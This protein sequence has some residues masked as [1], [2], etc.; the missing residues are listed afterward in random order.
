MHELL[1][2]APIPAS[3]HH[4]LLQ[5]LTGLTAMQPNRTFERR[6][7]FKPYRRPGFVRPRPGGSQDVQ[8]TE[9]QKLQKMLNSGLYHMQV[10]G[11]IN[12]TD[13]GVEENGHK[14]D[15]VMGGMESGGADQRVKP[16]PG[17]TP[18][19]QVWKVEFKDTPE[20][21]AGSGVTSRGASTAVLPYGDVV[22]LMKAW[23]YDYIS[24]YVVEGNMF[25]LDDTVLF[26]HRILNYSPG[27]LKDPSRPTDSLPP[28]EQ[29]VPLDPSGTYILQASVTVQDVNPDMLK[30]AAHRLLRMKDRLKSVAKLEPA[31]RLA[32]DT[33]VK[34]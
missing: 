14:P 30:A 8:H 15:A 11:A 3:Q 4:D 20:A 27:W 26:L 9:V 29:L 12:A 7:I 22:P 25:I 23:G 28:M 2:F 13:F 34:S 31:D 19:N 18:S 33:R 6:L 21:G 17:Y 5:Q 1:L 10:V 16:G 32:L 24:E